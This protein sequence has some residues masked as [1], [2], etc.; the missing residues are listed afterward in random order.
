MGLDDV[1][2]ADTVL[3]DVEGAA[4]RLVI[5]GRSLDDLAGRAGFEDV[6][7]LLWDGFFDDLPGDLRP[8]LGRARAEVFA[9]VRALDARLPPY[10]AMRALS[11][12]STTAPTSRRLCASS[13]RPPCSPP[14]RCAAAPAWTRSRRTPARA[15]PP[16][17]C[18][19]SGKA[20]SAARA[21]A[22][23]AYL[24]TV[25][26]HGL[27]ASTFAA[28]VVASTGAGLSRR[29]WRRSAR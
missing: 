16:T 6:A 27:N 3:S 22:L 29:R 23:D 10:D 15:T 8:A 25:C 17:S 11:P 18:G 5:R 2:A 13:P 26:D 20:P 9:E 21:A 28:R 24:V 7:R 14:P 1:I 4:G 12:A 19:C